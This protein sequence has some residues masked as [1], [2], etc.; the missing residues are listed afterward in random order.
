MK[1]KTNENLLSAIFSVGRIT[2]EKI[3]ESKCFRDFT[4]SE[5][6]ILM[7]LHE[8]HSA[9]MKSIAD[10]LHIKPSS[11]TPVIDNLV[12]KNTIKRIEKPGDRRVICLELTSNGLKSLHEKNKNVQ[13]IISKFFKKL[14]EEDKKNLI[15]IIQKI[16]AEKI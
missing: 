1:N 3:H 11:A 15:K 5:M 9:T 4:Q 13:K 16:H 7:F 2:R 10:Y 14:S 8:K 6:E 12:K